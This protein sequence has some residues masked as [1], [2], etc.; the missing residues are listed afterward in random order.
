MATPS[1][2]NTPAEIDPSRRMNASQYSGSTA[3]G[4]QPVIAGYNTGNSQTVAAGDLIWWGYDSKNKKQTFINKSQANNAWVFLPDQTRK[5]IMQKMD[6]AFGQGKWKNTTLQYYWQQAVNGANYALYAQNQLVGVPD[7]FDR[8][9][10]EAAQQQRA[11]AGGGGGG[12]SVTRQIRLSD[13]QTATALLD[14]ALEK[15]L[16]QTATRQQRQQFLEALNKQEAKNATITRTS[17]SAGGTNVVT[18]GGFNPSTFAEDY[19][20]GMQ[21]SAEFQAATTY[22]DAFMSA[23]RPVVS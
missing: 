21:G 3:M 22:L 19:A 11:A 1:V 2:P 17:R 12:T 14:S 6:A 10:G 4:S 18:T 9:I 20:K 8:I 7:V 13:P 23:L 5:G 15:A 16:G